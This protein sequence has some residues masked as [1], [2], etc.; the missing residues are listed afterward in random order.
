MHVDLLINYAQDREYLIKYLEL[1]FAQLLHSQFSVHDK[2][3]L[4]K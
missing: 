4:W 3:I 1:N 2:W